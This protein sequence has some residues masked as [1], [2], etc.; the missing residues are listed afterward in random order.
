MTILVHIIPIL[1]AVNELH[2]IDAHQT[3]TNLVPE[4]IF[5]IK[6]RDIPVSERDVF[7]D[8]LENRFRDDYDVSTDAFFNRKVG[9]D[10]PKPVT[11]TDAAVTS[12]LATKQTKKYVDVIKHKVC[13]CS[14]KCGRCKMCPKQQAISWSTVSTQAPVWQRRVT[15]RTRSAVDSLSAW[16]KRDEIARQAQTGRPRISGSVGQSQSFSSVWQRRNEFGRQKFD[17]RPF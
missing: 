7:N 16:D 3:T 13:L 11:T 8:A 12:T 5:L 2:P 10:L 9:H 1:V 6:K 4:T 14:Y 15:A 17:P